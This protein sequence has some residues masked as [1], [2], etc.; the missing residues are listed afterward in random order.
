[1]R[2]CILIQSSL[3]ISLTPAGC[4]EFIGYFLLMYYITDA[5]DSCFLL[6]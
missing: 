6:V 5:S 1:M 2:L 4:L 3:I